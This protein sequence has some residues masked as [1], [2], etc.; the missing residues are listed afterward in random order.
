VTTAAQTPR[1]SADELVRTIFEQLDD[2][3]WRLDRRTPEVAVYS[4]RGLPAPVVGY[5]TVT[6]HDADLSA[7]AGFLGAGLF[8]A[9]RTLNARFAFGEVLRDAPRVVR[10]GFTMPPGFAGREF[11]H[12]LHE[13]SVG[14][15]VRV[16]AYDAVDESDLPPPHEGFLRCPMHPSGQRLTRLATGR[17]RVEHL[18]VYELAGCVPAWAQNILFHRGHIGAYAA[19]WQA[20][21][22]HFR[23]AA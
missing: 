7:L 10:T 23:S 20:L 6:E 8:D 2:P 9:F 13:A 16:V 18:M 21:V 11:V 1:R 14:D 15:D 12:L 19:E 3:G 22:S 4:H 5:R 17:V